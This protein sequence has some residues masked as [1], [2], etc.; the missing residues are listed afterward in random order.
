[1]NLTENHNKVWSPQLVL[2][3]KNS[4]SGPRTRYNALVTETYSFRSISRNFA[5]T[6]RR[7]IIVASKCPTFHVISHCNE[8]AGDSPVMTTS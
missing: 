6:Y 1:M 8:C 7:D 3:R 2:N 4:A 5:V